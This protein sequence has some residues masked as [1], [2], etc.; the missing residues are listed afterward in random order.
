MTDTEVG[1]ASSQGFL[2]HCPPPQQQSVSMATPPLISLQY[3][4]TQLSSDSP[5]LSSSL[6]PYNSVLP[7]KMASPPLFP[8]PPSSL[9]PSPSITGHRSYTLEFKLSVVD[10]IQST[11]ASIRAASKQFGVDR[12]LIRT[13]LNSKETLSS[14]LVVHGPNRRKLHRGARPISEAVDRHVLHFLAQQ[15][16]SGIQ[17]SWILFLESL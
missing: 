2:L 12:K 8:S 11:N 10:W 6:L 13:W 9:L 15:R 4:A 7:L 16:Q 14:A 17:V 3:S 1:V 5:L